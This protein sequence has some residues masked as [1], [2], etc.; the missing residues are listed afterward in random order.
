MIAPN[1]LSTEREERLHEVL[2]AY[3]E[4]EARGQAPDTRQ[5]LEAHVEFA[6]E[7]ADFLA[8]R[9]RVESII[10]P[11]RDVPTRDGRGAEEDRSLTVA[12]PLHLLGDFHLVREIGRGGMGI[13]YEAEQLSLNRRV[14]VK[15]LPFAVALD[16]K[17]LHR[18]KNEAQTAAL[19]Q[20]PNIVPVYAVGCEAGVH[21]F[22]MQYIQ[23]RSLAAL[24]DEKTFANGSGS[25][26]SR[27]A[28]IAELGLR[29]ALALEHAHEQ[30]VVHRDIKPAN[31]LLDER[32]ELWI[33]DFGLALFQ[34]SPNVTLSGEL[35][36]TLRYMSPEQARAKRGLIDHRTDIYSL[37][38]T[39]YELLT[40]QPV[41]AGQD[42]QELLCQIA[43]QEPILP[44]SLDRT[45]TV[46]L[47]TVLLKAM[48]KNPAERYASAGE[49]ADDLKRFLEHKPIRARRPTLMDKAAKPAASHSRRRRLGR[50]PAPDGRTDE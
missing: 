10:A 33:T 35:V 36:G 32:G 9:Q 30:G 6:E 4:A 2:L 44:R 27:D 19:L 24:I 37:G 43:S 31:L 39:L 12:A 14:A 42:G 28:R 29:A 23:G 46:D 40:L 47:E 15:V 11:L 1:P 26:T 38:A 22:A 34:T 48:A 17:Q 41:F 21:Y 13:V 20:H 49:L 3:L 25:D 8:S 5:F 7:L 45:I 50:F 16:P 18:F